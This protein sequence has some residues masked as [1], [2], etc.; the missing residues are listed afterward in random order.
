MGECMFG[1]IFWVVVAGHIHQ[2]DIQEGD[3][4]FQ[5]GIG[6]IS[7]ANDQFD[8]AE[9]SAITKTV[10]AFHNF[11]AD[12]KDLHKVNCAAERCSLQGN[13]FQK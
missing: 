7:T 5:V 2:G 12:G 8:I 11:V 1:V 4:V 3:E 13:T 10:Q 6:Q 9:M